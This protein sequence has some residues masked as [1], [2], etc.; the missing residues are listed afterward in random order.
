MKVSLKHATNFNIGHKQLEDIT[1]T[2]RMYVGKIKL[3]T[4][5]T[6]YDENSTLCQSWCDCGLGPNLDCCYFIYVSCDPPC[7]PKF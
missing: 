2:C 7:S 5:K 1:K 4:K 3:K 6:P